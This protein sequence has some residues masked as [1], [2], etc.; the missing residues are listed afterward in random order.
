M[1]YLKFMNFISEI[2]KI[3]KITGIFADI[4]NATVMIFISMI[5]HKTGNI[6]LLIPLTFMI[7]NFLLMIY[8]CF[9]NC[10][11]MYGIYLILSALFFIIILMSM[12]LI[13]LFNDP[14]IIYNVSYIFILKI[15]IPII[16]IIIAI[17]IN[18]WLVEKN[19]SM[20]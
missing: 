13:N 11:V 3:S 5:Y 12:F 18:I 20:L 8:S 14:P 2:T 4:V 16:I 9:H 7:L 19:A 10:S 15:N 1:I 6:F 17:L